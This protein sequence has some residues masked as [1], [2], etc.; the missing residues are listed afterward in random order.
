MQDLTRRIDTSSRY[1]T[2]SSASAVR[3]EFFH[4]TGEWCTEAQA[5]AACFSVPDGAPADFA[6][7][8]VGVE[9]RELDARDWVRQREGLHKVLRG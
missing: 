2:L 4:L 3:E 8:N 1:S 5:V 9:M 6:A 7:L